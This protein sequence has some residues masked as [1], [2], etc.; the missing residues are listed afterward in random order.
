MASW[1]AERGAG[2]AYLSAAPPPGGRATGPAAPAPATDATA[3]GGARKRARP[4]RGG[5][6]VRCRPRPGLAGTGGLRRALKARLTCSGNRVGACVGDDDDGRRR[7]ACRPSAGR[8]GFPFLRPRGLGEPVAPISPPRA[9]GSHYR[10]LAWDAAGPRGYA[11]SRQVLPG[12]DGRRCPQRTRHASAH[13]CPAAVRS[14]AAAPGAAERPAPPGGIGRCG[15][16]GRG[17][18]RRRAM[19]IP[20]GDGGTCPRD[21]RYHDR[22]HANELGHG[23]LPVGLVPARP[24]PDV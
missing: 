8:A 13:G 12:E 4:W 21:G 15:P 11:R 14:R 17:R 22:K 20:K 24:E 18:Y 7:G 5:R 23:G 9:T 6:P 2:R 1:I 19:T 10:R 3:T 16:Q